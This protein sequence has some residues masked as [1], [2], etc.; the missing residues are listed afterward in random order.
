VTI[1]GTSSCILQS[2]IFCT[3]PAPWTEQ[4]ATTRQTTAVWNFGWESASEF[5]LQMALPTNRSTRKAFLSLKANVNLLKIVY[6]I[7]KTTGCLFP[8]CYQFK[9]VTGSNNLLV[10]VGHWFQNITYLLTPRSRVLLEKLTGSAASQEI[11]LILCKPK[12]HYRT[13]KCPPPLP[14]VPWHGASSVCG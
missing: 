9:S 4:I 13:H 12:V 8:V 2:F 1:S 6:K 14:M 7:I 5:L 10:P 3:S 11:P